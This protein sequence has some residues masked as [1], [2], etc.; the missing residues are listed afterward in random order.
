VIERLLLGMRRSQMGQPEGFP[1]RLLTLQLFAAIRAFDDF[2]PENDPYREHDF[3]SVDWGAERMLWNIDYYEQAL[4][5][6]ADPLSAERQRVLTIMT[7]DECT[8]KLR[9]LQ[10]ARLFRW[11]ELGRRRRGRKR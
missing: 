4:Q 6:W 5:Y 8:T 2:T 7:S 9:Q 11:K 1:S 3:G 10:F